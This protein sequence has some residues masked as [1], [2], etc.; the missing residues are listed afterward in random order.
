MTYDSEMSVQERTVQLAAVIPNAEDWAGKDPGDPQVRPPPVRQPDVADDIKSSA[1]PVA[2]LEMGHSIDGESTVPVN[3]PFTALFTSGSGQDRGSVTAINN[4][5]LVLSESGELVE[6]I[7]PAVTRT[8]PH[9]SPARFACVRSRGGVPR[10]ITTGGSFMSWD[11]S[12]FTTNDSTVTEPEVAEEVT[13]ETARVPPAPL[14]RRR[15]G[16]PASVR[17][18][19]GSSPKRRSHQYSTPTRTCRTHPMRRSPSSRWCFVNRRLTTWRT[20]RGDSRR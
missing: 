16:L 8:N 15:S 9:P 1:S 2:V 7:E 3:I 12:N 4:R 11:S 18:R 13:G 14:R 20:D 6:L 19:L 10:K 5:S 17:R